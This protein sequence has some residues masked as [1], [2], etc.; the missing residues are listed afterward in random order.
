M[1]LWDREGGK[2]GREG[3]G[4]GWIGSRRGV[5]LVSNPVD[6]SAAGII[7][8]P[9]QIPQCGS[10]CTHVSYL[11]NTGEKSCSWIWQSHV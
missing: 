8:F 6:T 11:A 9:D 10:T 2:L 7:S 1:A 5:G 4:H 3:A